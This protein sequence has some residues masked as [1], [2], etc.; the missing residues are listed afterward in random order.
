MLV[1]TTLHS[2][3]I[4]I[5][6]TVVSTAQMQ[7]LLKRLEIAYLKPKAVQTNNKISIKGKVED[8]LAA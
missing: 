6:K 7:T 8:L 3:R 5:W 4:T 2:A 1:I